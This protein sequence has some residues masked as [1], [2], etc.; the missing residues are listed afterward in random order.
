MRIL[1]A[2]ISLYLL[3]GMVSCE[4]EKCKRVIVKVVNGCVS[5]YITETIV[6]NQ[7]YCGSELEE[8]RKQAGYRELPYGNGTC[9]ITT[10]VI[11]Q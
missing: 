10:I 8:I 7:E 5:P 11:E 1:L 9:R 2:I 3:I 4:K 6:N